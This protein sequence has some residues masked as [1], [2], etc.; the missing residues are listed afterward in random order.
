[1]SENEPQVAWKVIEPGAEVVTSDGDTGA[2]VARVVGDVDAD[3]FTGL[4]VKPGLL[5][6]ERLVPSER[7]VGIWPN[8]VEVDLTKDQLE[9]LPEYEDAPAVRFE[10]GFSS[11]FRRLFGRG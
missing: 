1:M 6:S 3:V 8:R 7:V 10:P 5:A 4:A 11:L 2:K 9:R